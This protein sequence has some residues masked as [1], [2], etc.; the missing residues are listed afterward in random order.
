MSFKKLFLTLTLATPLIQSLTLQ[1]LPTRYRHNITTLSPYHPTTS[2]TLPASS[3][4]PPQ[5]PHHSSAN[6]D[7]IQAHNTTHMHFYNGTWTPQNQ[8]FGCKSR[9]TTSPSRPPTKVQTTIITSIITESEKHTT[10]VAGATFVTPTMKQ[11]TTITTSHNNILHFHS[12]ANVPELIRSAVLRADGDDGDDGDKPPFRDHE[13][14]RGE[15]ADGSGSGSGRSYL[16]YSVVPI[17]LLVVAFFFLGVIY[18]CHRWGV[19]CWRDWVRGA[20]R[21]CRPSPS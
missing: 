14:C 21:K 2:T 16:D 19:G 10:A 11:V 17:V 9:K 15:N 20:W 18:C 5:P 12:I 8:T 3:P 6:P 1:P 4:P 13:K 7:L